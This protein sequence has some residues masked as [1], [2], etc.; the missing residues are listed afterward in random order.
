MVTIIISYRILHSDHT[1]HK[2]LTFTT[3]VNDYVICQL[4]FMEWFHPTYHHI[5][6]EALPK[7][8]SPVSSPV[9]NF[10]F[11][12]DDNKLLECF[13]NLLHENNLPFAV[14]LQHI[15]KGQQHDRE[16]WEH[17]LAHPLCYP[18]Q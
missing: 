5:A 6:V 14:N 1:N 10:L 9:N 15:T 18:E 2:N 11:L 12:L 17:H 4:N 7:R 16:L 3:A 13:L 8:E